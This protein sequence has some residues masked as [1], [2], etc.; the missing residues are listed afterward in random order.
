MPS[1]T[2]AAAPG[3]PLVA[4][5]VLAAVLAFGV[6][7]LFMQLQRNGYFS[8][9]APLIESDK[10]AVMP[11]SMRPILRHYTGVAA[12][13]HWFVTINVFWAN[14]L[15]GSLPECNLYALQ[16]G[17]QLPAIVIIMLVESRRVAGPNWLLR[18]AVIWGVALRTVGFGVI[19]PL[20]A[21]LYFVLPRQ[22][23]AASAEAAQL[24]DPIELHTVGP[25][26]ILGYFLPSALMAFP[27]EDAYSSQ[28]A[29]IVWQYFPVIVGVL[30]TGLSFMAKRLSIGMDIHTSK[31]RMSR[32]ALNHAYGFALTCATLCQW[33]TYAILVVAW[34]APGKLSAQLAGHLT[35]GKV[36]FP[37]PP[38]SDSP[39]NSP[40][41]AIH[42][43]LKWDQYT[44]SFAIL[45]WA[46]ALARQAGARTPSFGDVFRDTLVFG[47]AAA[48]MKVLWKRDTSL[49]SKAY[50]G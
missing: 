41:T 7:A 9:V 10:P 24:R 35:P 30:L 18:S 15:D 19:M 16:F 31:S 44:G 46:F 13:D 1:K 20:Y 11:G 49:L 38:H 39:M 29:N 21:L 17:G 50:A 28:R 6:D 34:G 48:G 5:A 43:F 36:F 47:P 32:D 26:F 37:E 42:E 45:V 8:A 2:A 23:S 27:Y 12:I 25:A 14:V 40:G 22:G 3:R 4:I 33:I